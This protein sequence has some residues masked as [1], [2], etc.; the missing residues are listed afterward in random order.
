MDPDYPYPLP[1]DGTSPASYGPVA[2]R[3]LAKQDS[4]LAM[5]NGDN[6]RYFAADV[7]SKLYGFKF[8]S[9]HQLELEPLM[10]ERTVEALLAQLEQLDAGA[11]GETSNAGADGTA[12]LTFDCEEGGG[13]RYGD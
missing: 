2:A 7:A 8:Q 13:S 6:Y 9:P 4:R 1:P 12:T 10:S 5:R 11:K 3:F